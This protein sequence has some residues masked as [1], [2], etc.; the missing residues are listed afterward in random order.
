AW[1]V[2][3]LDAAAVRAALSA[4]GWVLAATALYAVGHVANGEAWRGL[5]NAGGARVSFGGMVRHELTSLFWGTVLPGG[6]SGEVVKGI[7]VAR[8]GA[9]AQAAAVG[10]VAARVV[11]GTTTCL[12]GAACLP[13]SGYPARAAIAG[14]LLACAAGGVALLAGLRYAPDLPPLD[15]LPRG[16]LPD[17]R[18]LAVAAAW[19]TLARALFVGVFVCCFGAAGRP[20]GLADA[21]VTSALVALAQ[22]LPVTLGGYGVRELTIGGLG[23]LFAPGAVADAAAVVLG[24]L[25]SVTVLAGAAAEAARSRGAT[26]GS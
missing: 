2:S 21:T 4:P 15:R 1:F 26:D 3:R 14:G 16:P 24:L 11:S 10:L 13:A 19:S 7:R 5:V 8:E 6:V 9:G 23:R 12:L 17:L 18:A 20:L 22:L 25:V